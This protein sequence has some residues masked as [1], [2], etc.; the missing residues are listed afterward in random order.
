M[1]AGSSD[2][3]FTLARYRI[4]GSLDGSFGNNGIV[5]TTANLPAFGKDVAVQVDDKIV[6]VGYVKGEDNSEF[7]IARYNANGSPDNTFGSGQIVTT[8][9][10]SPLTV[11]GSG[12]AVI[13]QPG[14]KIVA[15]G[16][17]WGDNF[18]TF[19]VVRYNPN[20]SLDNSF[21]A[22][23]VVTTTLPAGP[24]FVSCTG[25]ALQP[26]G[27][28]IV[29]GTPVGDTPDGIALAR[30][31]GDLPPAFLTN[32]P[33]TGSPLITPTL[34][35]TIT[36]SRP[37]FDWEDAT[38]DVGVSYY[39][40]ILDGGNDALTLN[41]ETQF[42]APQSSYKPDVDLPNASYT[43]TVQ[44]HDIVGHVT[45]VITPANFIIE[46]AKESSVGVIYLPVV[47]KHD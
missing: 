13:I 34:G 20:G 37:L 30:Y 15:G 28:I 22:S 21:G 9:L 29:A 19:T 41:Q 8:P 40:L 6:V 24:P 46:S 32:Y 7:A 45:S 44:A 26:G 18:G 2:N 1:V 4:N 5:T 42:T 47:L 25:V 36:Q 33:A 12:K 38:D 27:K 31:I 14:G 11:G 35:V 3:R 10:T 43:W 23:G 39:T 16:D 17:S